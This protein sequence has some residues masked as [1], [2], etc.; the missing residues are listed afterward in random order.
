M[1][2]Q[3][4]KA[5][6]LLNERKKEANRRWFKDWGEGLAY[7]NECD[8]EYTDL[9]AVIIEEESSCPS[10]KNPERKTY[11]YCAEHGTSGCISCRN[12]N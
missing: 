12:G 7:C 10:C 1:Q 4:Y 9:Q 11:Y 8:H 6:S 3:Q 2:P 5:N